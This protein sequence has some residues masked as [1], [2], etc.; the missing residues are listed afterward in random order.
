MLSVISAYDKRDIERP[1]ILVM[2]VTLLYISIRVGLIKVRSQY[3]TVISPYP[4]SDTEILHIRVLNL[5]ST[6]YQMIET[7][8][9]LRKIS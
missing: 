2:S 5:Y 4:M 3:T 1:F 7:N 8:T 6:H 9:A